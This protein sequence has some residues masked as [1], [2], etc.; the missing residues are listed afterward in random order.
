MTI[1]NFEKV[2]Q[3]IKKNQNYYKDGMNIELS[4]GEP[5]LFLTKEH[6]NLIRKNNFSKNVFFRIITNGYNSNIID[7]LSLKKQ[8][9]LIQLSIDSLNQKLNKPFFNSVEN[10]KNIINSCIKNNIRLETSSV[11]TNEHTVNDIICLLDYLKDKSSFL[12]ITCPNN[13]IGNTYDIIKIY[14]E[15]IKWSLK[16]KTFKISI[17]G[18]RIYKDLI[19][20]PCSA[21]FR[22]FAVLP[23]LD[24]LKC[25]YDSVVVGNL[26]KNELF[27]LN[28]VQSN[29]KHLRTNCL[30]CEILNICRGG[31]KIINTNE[32][33][34]SCI[35]RKDL[36]KLFKKY[37]YV[38]QVQES[39]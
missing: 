13:Y 23:N 18:F 8:N 22:H 38:E 1:T 30:D 17:F 15:I 3:F 34:Y 9:I 5:T 25:Q 37:N 26:L 7:E 4:G 12:K 21:G 32:H 24:I 16:T 27:N 36:W 20:Y 2:L 33:K 39:L 14:E 19:L 35:I 29:I 11:F 31:C 28:T 6:I 10:Q